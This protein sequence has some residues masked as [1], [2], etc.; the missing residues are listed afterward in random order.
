MKKLVLESAEYAKDSYGYP[1][2]FVK[3]N[4]VSVN[5]AFGKRTLLEDGIV[6]LEKEGLGETIEFVKDGQRVSINNCTQDKRIVQLV[7]NFN[8]IIDSKEKIPTGMFD[9]KTLKL[10]PSSNQDIESI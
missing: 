7:R 10:K 6:C 2:L 4:G 5:L 8:K 9:L 1:A 3:I